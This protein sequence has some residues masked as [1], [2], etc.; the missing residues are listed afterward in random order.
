M[1]EDSRRWGPPVEDHFAPVP[2]Q[3]NGATIEGA[4]R[5]LLWRTWDASRPHALWILLNPSMADERI[6]DPTLRHCKAFTTS[7]RFGGLEI[8]N[9]FALRTPYP[10]DLYQA[11]NPVGEENDQY[12]IAAVRRATCIILAWGAHGSYR[13]RDRAV[14]ALIKTHTALAPYCLGA[15]RSN[16]PR[17]PLY[18]A[19]NK[20]P[21]PFVSSA[22]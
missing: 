19:R 14:L 22:P 7:W 6:D 20:Q 8:V 5:Y 2:A 9:L 21:I 11:A 3:D 1:D 12:I 15:T 18:I 4:Y 16:S 10:R 13:Q 17:H